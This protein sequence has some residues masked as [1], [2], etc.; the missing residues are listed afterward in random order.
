MSNKKLSTQFSVLEIIRIITLSFR[1]HFEQVQKKVSSNI[2]FMYG[3][4][5]YL[6]D[7]VMT[8][9]LNCHVHTIIDYG[10]TIWATLPDSQ[11]LRL[12][13]KIDQ[14]LVNFY[15]PIIAK[16]QRIQNSQV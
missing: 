2:G 7:K 1:D 8:K 15:L 12:Q 13:R 3:I 16:K 10:I 14:Y 6:T 4:K 11:L 9:L 5:R